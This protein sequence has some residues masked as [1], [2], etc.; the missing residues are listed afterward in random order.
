MRDNLGSSL[1]HWH[2]STTEGAPGSMAT[3]TWR[4]SS[5]SDGGDQECV[6]VAFA[7]TAAVRDSKNTAGP[8]LRFTAREWRTFI[9]G[10][11]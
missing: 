5:Y 4:K 10:Q 3:T 6:E 11:R 1:P 9:Q 2:T 7:D 8:T